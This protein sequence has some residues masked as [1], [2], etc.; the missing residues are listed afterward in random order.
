[1]SK[2]HKY[3]F[4]QFLLVTVAV[5]AA[6]LL[7]CFLCDSDWPVDGATIID[8][9]PHIRPDYTGTV[10]P[11]NIAPLNFIVKEPGRRYYVRIYSD[12]GKDIDVHSKKPEIIIPLKAWRKLLQDNQAGKL[13]FDVYVENDDGR[14]KRFASITNK[15]SRAAVDDYLVYRLIKPIYYNWFD[16]GIYQRHLPGYHESVVLRGRSFRE[17]YY[18]GCVN[19]HAFCNNRTDKMT[20]GIRSDYGAPTLLSENG[21]VSKIGTKF[22]Y[23]AWHPTGRIVMYSANKVRQFFHMTGVEVRDVVDLDSALAY[24]DL[25]SKTVKVPPQ[26]ADKSRLETYPTWSPDGDYLYFCSAPIL[27]S[28]RNVVPPKNYE[29]VLYDLMRIS[30]DI[31]T[32]SWG[33]LETVLSASQTGKSIMLPRISP[34][35]RFLMFCMCDY[36]C[37]PIYQPS[38]DLYMMDL[39][40]ARQTGNFAYRRLE[41][42]SD[43]CESWHCWSSNGRWIVFSSKRRDGVFTRSYISYVDEDGEA[44]KPLLLPQKNPAFYDSFLKTYSVPEF[45][46]EPVRTREKDLVHAVRSPAQIEV[47]MPLTGATPKAGPSEPWQQDRE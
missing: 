22:G 45:V 26:L 10:I 19:C 15:I 18:A 7:Y 25:K 3:R 32:D 13:Y 29:K 39:E 5:L 17:Q 41:I 12:Q 2:M 44:Y 43:R 36:G 31:D 24:Y 9:P 23:T 38:S 20:I 11:P 14:W 40:A 34:D 28:D 21:K 8:K 6:T 47:T 33:Q 30:Y 16:I 37:F 46:A 27:W 42:N 35:G 4:C 1:M